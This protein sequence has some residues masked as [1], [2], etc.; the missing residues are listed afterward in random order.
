MGKYKK[1]GYKYLDI[2]SQAAMN[3]VE[4][5][6]WPSNDS[7]STCTV[8]VEHVVDFRIILPV[9]FHVTK[10]SEHHFI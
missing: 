4:I 3:N 8:K 1:E 7:R 9:K 2:L 6:L 5:S 10:I